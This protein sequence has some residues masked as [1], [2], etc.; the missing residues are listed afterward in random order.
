MTQAASDMGPSGQKAG[1]GTRAPG[2]PG[3]QCPK[4]THLPAC[5]SYIWF[6]QRSQYPKSTG[7]NSW[8]SPCCIEQ[9]QAQ[10]GAGPCLS[11]TARGTSLGCRMGLAPLGTTASSS[12]TQHAL[13]VLRSSHSVDEEAE[14]PNGNTKLLKSWEP[15]VLNS[16]WTA[17]WRG[18]V[19][20][21]GAAGVTLG[22]RLPGGLH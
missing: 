13:L 1:W 9:G 19:A 21:L 14:C 6:G 22:L 2:L 16:S 15:L 5:S 11:H 17:G 3:G 8:T 12:L 18:R 20:S 10:R 4:P 7:E